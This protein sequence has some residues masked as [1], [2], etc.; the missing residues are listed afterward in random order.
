[1]GMENDFESV[2]KEQLEV[3]MCRENLDDIPQFSLPPEVSIRPYQAGDGKRWFTIQ[4]ATDHFTTFTPKKFQ[5]EFG[6]DVS[7]LKER[8]RFMTDSENNAIGTTSAWSFDLNERHYG[9]IHWVAIVPE[10]Q[11]HGLAKPLMT[12]ICNLLKELG[13]DKGLLHTQSMRFPAIKLYSRFGFVPLIRNE[14]EQIA[15]NVILER[16]N[17]DYRV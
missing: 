6:T 10:W 9:L 14:K 12:A 8:V 5:E 17:A 7:L 16:I 15:W 4:S 13:H 1:M 3:V 2:L 11:G